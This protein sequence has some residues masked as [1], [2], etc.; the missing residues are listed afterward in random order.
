MSHT[1]WPVLTDISNVAMAMGVTFPLTL[2]EDVQQNVLDSVVDNFT[3]K[4]HRTWIATDDTRYY[5]GNDTGEIEVDEYIT[6]S[7]LQVVGWFGIT[8][9]AVLE[10]MVPITRPGFPQTRIQIYRGSLPG[11]YRVW[12]DRFPVGRSNIAI[13]AK[14]GWATTIPADVWMAVNYKAA[15]IL[16]NIDNYEKEGFLIKWQEAGVTEVRNYMDPFKFF[17]SGMTYENIIDQ[18]KKPAG[19]FIRKQA[20][21]LI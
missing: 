5:D 20:R 2:V 14:W 10:N 18:Y 3:N 16:V 13:T 6:L 4:T 12:I 8:T 9:G 19:Y 17:H 15:G 21:R 1:A 11:L 7:T